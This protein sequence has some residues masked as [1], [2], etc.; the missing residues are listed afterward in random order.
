MN[1][2]ENTVY[3]STNSYNQIKAENQKFR[4]FID[5]MFET[6][7]L[8]KDKTGVE[9]DAKLMAEII[10][11]IYPEAYK[12]RLSYLRRNDTLEAMKKMK[13]SEGKAYSDVTE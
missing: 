9:F 10:H 7:T 1:M 8:S 3:L 2:K 5:R 4:M 11:I 13:E 6:A 12:K